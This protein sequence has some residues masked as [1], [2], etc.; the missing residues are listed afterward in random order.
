MR[1]VSVAVILVFGLFVFGCLGSPPAS[2]NTSKSGDSMNKTNDSMVKP[3]DAMENKSGDAMP[4]KEPGVMV[5]GSGNGTV[6]GGSGGSG[7]GGYSDM[8]FAALVALGVPLQCDI[9]STSGGVTTTSKIYMK[10]STDMRIE[11]PGSDC[12]NTVMIMKNDEKKLYMGCEGQDEFIPGSGCKWLVMKTDGS[13]TPTG[14]S[15]S[16]NTN[17]ANVPPSQ[18]NCEAWVY[19]DNLFEVDGEVCDFSNMGN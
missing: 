14:G 2:N 7:S 3:G 13:G 10:G 11:V 12:A 6:S 17:Y 8:E 18:I 1:E 9:T 19:N 16:V 4:G 15:T 5:N